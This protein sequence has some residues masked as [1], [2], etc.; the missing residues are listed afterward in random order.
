MAIADKAKAAVLKPGDGNGHTN[1]EKETRVAKNFVGMNATGI[2]SMIEA[3][4]PMMMQVLPKTITPERMIQICA[5]IVATKPEL[6]AC[7]AASVLGAI[8]SASI[9]GLDPTPELQFVYFIPR[10]NFKKTLNA[11]VTEC[12]FTIGAA[13]WKELIIRN[14]GTAKMSA[15]VVRERDHFEITLGDDARLIHK[16]CLDDAGEMKYVYCIVQ[17][18]NGEKVFRYLNREQVYARRNKSTNIDKKTGEM[19]DASPWVGDFEEEMWIKTAIKHIRKFIRISPQVGQAAAIDD[20]VVD[21]AAIDMT[22]KTFDTAKIEKESKS[23]GQEPEDAKVVS[24]TKKE[25]E[26]APE[27]KQEPEPDN[28]NGKNRIT[29]NDPNELPFDNPAAGKVPDSKAKIAFLRTVEVH[30]G[31]IEP[32]MGADYWRELPGK[33]GLEKFEQAT[34]N[35]FDRILKALA[36]ESTAAKKEA[37]KK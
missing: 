3:Y 18:E 26:K 23:D 32:V 5:S 35:D 2:A 28:T 12:T 19:K 9:L 29:N 16:P 1:G 10:S 15:Y 34:Q 8:V 31:N 33:L 24:E 27:Q 25:P 30:R 7:T 21:I 36:Y 4:K 22:N 20:K 14:G 13:G 6:K 17:L 37:A 11:Y